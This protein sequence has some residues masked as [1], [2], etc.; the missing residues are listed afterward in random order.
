MRGPVVSGKNIMPVGRTRQS[1]PYTC[2][3][4]EAT[5]ET[6]RNSSVIFYGGVLKGYLMIDACARMGK[7]YEIFHNVTYGK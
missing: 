7:E 6:A 3:R 2:S 5:L 4:R 1:G